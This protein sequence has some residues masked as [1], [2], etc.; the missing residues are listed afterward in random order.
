MATKTIEYS[1]LAAIVASLTILGGI[2]LDTAENV[3]YCESRGLVMQCSRL[4]S[5]G[6]TCYNAELGERRCSESWQKIIKSPTTNAADADL[7]SDIV[8]MAAN[9]K[10]YLCAVPRE[11]SKKAYGKCTTEDGGFAYYGELP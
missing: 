2:S 10:T 9:G 8:Q 7:G 1:V 4:S 11:V 5:S 6:I 3:Y